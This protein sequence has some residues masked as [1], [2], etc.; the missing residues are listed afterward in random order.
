IGIVSLMAFLAGFSALYF[1]CG[2]D[3][4][5]IV[6]NR[7]LFKEKLNE[8]AIPANASFV[9]L[10]A[11]QT[12]VKIIPAEPLE[13]GS[14]YIWGTFGGFFYC[15]LGTEIGSLIIFLLTKIFGIRFVRLFADVSKINEWSFIKDSKKK[16]LIIF[17]I[18]I[19][20][21]TPK[22]L[23]TYFM[24]LTNTKILPFLIVSGIARIPAIISSTYC[25]SSL[26]DKNYSLFIAALAVISVF[27]AAGTYFGAKYVSKL[28]TQC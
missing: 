4:L 20:P 6:S 19:I 3:L 26:I 21:G 17:I 22:D 11:F 15:M 13:I 12:V 7:D 14:G 8:F 23:I 28:K 27:S 10:R 16:Y 2:K 25:G 18:Y 9:L 5:A 1:T 24:G